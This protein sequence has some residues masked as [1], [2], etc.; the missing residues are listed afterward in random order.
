MHVWASITWILFGLNL[1]QIALAVVAWRQAHVPGVRAISALILASSIY[2]GCSALEWSP[3]LEH[4]VLLLKDL[5]FIGIAFL[6]PLTICAYVD[7]TGH[8]AWLSRRLRLGLFAFA[9][10]NLVVKWCDPWLHLV[11]REFMILHRDGWN[12]QYIVSGPW[13]AVMNAYLMVAEVI[14]LVA[15][16]RTWR[17]ANRVFRR[18]LAALAFAM[19]FPAIVHILRLGGISPV[20]DFDAV[21]SA[22]LVSTLVIAWAVWRE[23]LTR[24]API[25]RDAFFDMYGGGLVVAD[26]E[27]TVVDLNPAAVRILG[28][29]AGRAVGLPIGEVLADRP[30]LREL[31]AA[32]IENRREFSE[33]M[34]EG[35]D[36]EARWTPL[37]A[38]NGRQRGYLLALH[39]IT[40]RKRIEH[41]LREATETALESAHMKSR[42]LANMSHEIRTPMNGVVGMVDLLLDTPLSADQRALVQTV[43]SS[44]DALL[45]IINDI[46]D[47]S[48][49]EAGQ[50][51]FEA[52]PFDL[53]D[54]TEGVLGLLAER[55]EAKEIELACLIDDD[56]PR[57][58]VGDPGRLKQVLL[59]LV[60][61]GLKFTER[62]EVVVRVGLVERMDDRVRLKFSIA[63]TGIGLTREQQAKLFRPFVQAEEG[64]TRKYGGTGLG[65]AICRELVNRMGGEIGVESEVGRGSTFWFTGVF[66][67]QQPAPVSSVARPALSGQRV[68][69]ADDHAATREVIRKLVTAMGAEV[70]VVGRGPDAVD[71]VRQAAV[72]GNP[73]ALALADVRMPGLGGLDLARALRTASETGRLRVLLLAPVGFS[74]A[75]AELQEAGVER[76]LRKPVLGDQLRAAL[77]GTAEP[78]ET[79]AERSSPAL[80]QALRVLIAEDNPVNQAVARRQL[81]KFG[82]TPVIVHNGARAVE[83]ACSEPFDVV[84]MDCQMPEMDGFEATRR[85]RVWEARHRVSAVGRRPLY[86]IAIT[87][88]AMVGDRESC[89]AAGMDDYVSKPVRPAELAAALVRASAALRGRPGVV[90][91][92]SGGGV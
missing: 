16:V 72:E 83:M 79:R 66:S 60:G 46:L 74:P 86:V 24:I 89:L 41:R 2:V 42:F 64:T 15:V 8:A 68:L 20:T 5:E 80:A 51:V 44:A 10:L 61:N 48:K 7:F 19:V 45:T 63:D 84:L 33:L 65:L 67:L 75:I 82:Y 43:R 12:A 6:P 23:R 85:I 40:E 34:V 30:V 53:T 4:Q 59:N 57:Q 26:V 69:V 9:A 88:N 73:F 11:H 70:T 38:P 52:L 92:K 50:L 91:G 55:A 62:G 25:G 13:Y 14:A 35:T 36:W 27:R 58:L 47:F 22:L 56:V 54:P 87:A 28:L 31:C 71:Q 49:I 76:V 17:H 77:G 29:G 39:D 78:P 32:E 21:P 18:Q 37:T 81:E 3:A 1:G 90:A